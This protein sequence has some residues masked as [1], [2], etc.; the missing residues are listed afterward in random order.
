[1]V[2]SVSLWVKREN[3]LTIV[4]NSPLWLKPVGAS[5]F[6]HF[7][8][9]LLRTDFEIKTERISA[10]IRFASNSIDFFS[11]D[12]PW[13]GR[14][15]FDESCWWWLSGSC[16]F[17]CSVKEFRLDTLESLE[18]FGREFELCSSILHR[19]RTVDEDELLFCVESFFWRSLLEFDGVRL[20]DELN[21]STNENSTEFDRFYFSVCHPFG[22]SHWET[23]VFEL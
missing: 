15:V 16:P 18:E 5:K 1:M 10:L 20:F 4:E 17:I 19:G 3:V 22:F 23:S 14:R 21:L 13:L 2:V 11:S 9:K 7:T 12:K 6:S 8:H